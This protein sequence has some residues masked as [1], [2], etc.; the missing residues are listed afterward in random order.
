MKIS[1]S[2]LGVVPP[3]QIDLKPLT[4]FVGENGTGK[5][6]TVYTIASIFGAYGF[7]K[8]VNAY[9]QGE[10]TF[11]YAP[12]EKVT[13]DLI[14]N[15][16]A[17]LNIVEFANENIETYINEIAK[18]APG[19]MN[20]FMA[21]NRVNFG[22]MSISAKL[23]VATK[24]ALIRDTKD[25]EVRGEGFLGVKKD[26][27]DVELKCL[28][29]TGTDQLYFYTKVSKKVS[30]EIPPPVLDKEIREFVSSVILRI[31]RATLSREAV[32]FPTERPLLM[33]WPIPPGREKRKKCQVGK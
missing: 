9:F 17:T 7:N 10:T 27:S 4:V 13:K 21:T 2:G 6:W 32:V 1:I 26:S 28:K 8:Y 5:T 29:E 16:S 11:R 12:I 25:S 23:S 31:F 3:L 33:T 14:D 22:Q 19:W 15:G 30:G 24:E 18:I 20:H